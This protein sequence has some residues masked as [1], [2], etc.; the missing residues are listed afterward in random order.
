MPSSGEH[1]SSSA[2]VWPPQP[3]AAPGRGP[4]VTV[5]P[6]T[7]ALESARARVRAGWIDFERTWLDPVAEPLERR[8]E[9]CGWHPDTPGTACD[10]CGA[11][12]GPFEVGEF[13]CTSCRGRRLPWQ[14]L[15][16]LGAYEPPLSEWIQEIKF[17]RWRHLGLQLGGRLGGRVMDAGIDAG[18]ASG[19]GPWCVVPVASSWRRRMGRGI[20]HA[21]ILGLG[22]AK[23]LD[24]PVV[25]GLRRRHRPSQRAVPV[26]QRRGN[27]SGAFRGR[28]VVAGRS[29]LLVDDVTT[30]GAT[31]RA[32][33]RELRRMGAERIWVAV[34]AVAES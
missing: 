19:H 24:M 25:Q 15:V 27:V 12:I 2:F 7:E 30:T 20:D 33:S 10:R 16:R 34:L 32:A 22:V 21:A 1:D 13:G 3:E 5:A 26:S 4:E 17:T 31:I 28:R 9:A 8:I 29:V 6:A 11:T 14:R 18:E 23:A